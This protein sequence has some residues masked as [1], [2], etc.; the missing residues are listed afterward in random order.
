MDEHGRILYFRSEA[1]IGKET[2]IFFLI[3]LQE[4]GGRLDFLFS[5]KAWPGVPVWSWWWWLNE[6]TGTITRYLLF[7]KQNALSSGGKALYY[8]VI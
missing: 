5:G 3:E 6:R 8:F 2:E 7:S 1:D 4:H